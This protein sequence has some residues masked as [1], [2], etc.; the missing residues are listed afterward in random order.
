MTS[1]LYKKT[2]KHKENI[3]IALRG[4]KKSESHTRLNQ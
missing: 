2:E 3:S 1:G 4:K